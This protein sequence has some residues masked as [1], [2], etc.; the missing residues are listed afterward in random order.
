VSRGARDRGQA[1]VEL[2]LALP[3][4]AVLVM[5]MVQ[6]AAV[7]GDHLAVELA[8]REAARA[9]AVAAAPAASA[10]HAAHA[11]TSLRPL[12]VTTT[13]GAGRVSVTVSYASVTDAPLIG[14]AIG[15]VTLSATV[16][17][18]REPP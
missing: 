13:V 11:A 17:M 4:V 10:D 3:I 9:A 16:T 12:T 14:A 6:T 7:V 8:A 1:A 18:A 15:D 5:A 2:A